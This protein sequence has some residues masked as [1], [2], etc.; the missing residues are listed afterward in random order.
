M[1]AQ[2]RNKI[3]ERVSFFDILSSYLQ[4]LKF[5]CCRCNGGTYFANLKAFPLLMG[6]WWPRLSK[7]MD[8]IPI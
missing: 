6:I 7:R 1:Q 2:I 8:K 5:P 3:V 4:L